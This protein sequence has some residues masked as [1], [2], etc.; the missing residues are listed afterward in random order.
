VNATAVP[1]LIERICGAA[2]I[3][4]R[5]LHGGCVSR[6]VK[7]DL[8][9]G[10]SVVAKIGDA[11][12]ALDVE[13]W[14]LNRL[15][16]AGWPTPDVLHADAQ[17]LVMTHVDTDADGRGDLD[18]NAADLIAALHDEPAPAFG[19]DRMTVIAGLPQANMRAERWIPFF[20]EHRLIAMA[21][22]AYESSRI[23]GKLRARVEKLAQQLDKRLLE[24]DAPS[25]I[26]GDLWGGNVLARGG[27]IA[28]VID[29]ACYWADAEIELAF[30]TMFSTFG[31]RFYRRYDERR[32]I[33]PGFLE[34]RRDIYNLYPLLVHARLFGGSYVKS[35]ERTLDR[36]G[37]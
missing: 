6:V 4:V 19:F 31:P 5:A 35:I 32:G 9:G 28:A 26:H 21:H 7:A 30:T 37:V 12:S 18:V 36:F 33:A 29:P 25:L 2:P 3:S 11:S 13:G 8:P 24:P 1:E 23:T 27:R 20:A 34:E 15:R 22:Q 17:L 14:M 10:D 16:R